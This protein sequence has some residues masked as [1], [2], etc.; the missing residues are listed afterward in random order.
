M[1]PGV[2]SERSF[3]VLSAGP[4]ADASAGHGVSPD[5]LA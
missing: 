2:A 1:A 3:L 4:V 5:L